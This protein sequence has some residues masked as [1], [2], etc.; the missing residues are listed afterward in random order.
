MEY[1]LLLFER[2]RA[3]RISNDLGPLS[4]VSYTVLVIVVIIIFV[5][6]HYLK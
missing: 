5:F 4:I 3:S 2:K 1:D 6:I